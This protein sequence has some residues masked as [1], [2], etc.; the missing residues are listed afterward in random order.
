MSRFEGLGQ[1]PLPLDHVPQGWDVTTVGDVAF[2]ESGFASGEHNSSGHGLPHIRPMNVSREGRIELETLKSVP[3]E[4]S[5]KRLRP[6]DV[7]F[8]NT[9]SPA[10]VGKTAVFRSS[11][12]FGFS[13]HMTRVVPYGNVLSEFLAHYLHFL[14]RAGY[15]QHVCTNHVNQASVSSKRLASAVPVLL[16]PAAEQERIVAV[17]EECFSHL[18]AAGRSVERAQQNSR[19]LV[20]S[21][22]MRAIAGDWP[23]S[24]LAEHTTE[25]RYGS[26]AKASPTGDVPVLRM[27][28][29][30]APQRLGFVRDPQPDPR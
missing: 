27:D 5:D 2:V 14:W 30:D 12:E 19:R 13:N 7:V 21:A 3:P 24:T 17:I 15:F 8:N 6:G 22:V 10:L 23:V 4:K 20:R 16:P 18:D 11:G 9:N 1:F 29:A 28:A 26:S 25:Q